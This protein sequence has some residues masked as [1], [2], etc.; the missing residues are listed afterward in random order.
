MPVYILGIKRTQKGVR[1]ITDLAREMLVGSEKREELGGRLV[2]A[3]ATFGR[4]E[5]IV[6]VEFPNDKKALEAV[7]LN[8]M[9]GLVTVEVSEAVPLDEFS[10]VIAEPD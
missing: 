2:G 4:Y 9:K 10:R 1:E 6:I 8:R 7:N 5:V 3:W